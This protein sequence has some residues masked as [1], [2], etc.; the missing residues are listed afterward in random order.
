MRNVIPY[1]YFVSLLPGHF[2]QLLGLDMPFVLLEVKYN[3]ASQDHAIS[4]HD[5]PQ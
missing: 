2:I 4:F 5:N 1:A 3:F